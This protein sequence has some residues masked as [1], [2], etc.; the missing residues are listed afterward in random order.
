MLDDIDDAETEVDRF[1]TDYFS[2]GSQIE[3]SLIWRKRTII[4]IN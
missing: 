2:V 3:C 1:E 4:P